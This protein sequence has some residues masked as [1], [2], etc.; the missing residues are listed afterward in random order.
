MKKLKWENAEHPTALWFAKLAEEFA[1]VAV[2][3]Q[4]LDLAASPLERNAAESKLLDE[5]GHVVLI[6]RNFRRDVRTRGVT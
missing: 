5:L 4:A 6:A 3:I 1:E 2:E